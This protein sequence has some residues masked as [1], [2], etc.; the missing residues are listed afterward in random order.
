[1]MLRSPWHFP[2]GKTLPLALSFLG[3]TFVAQL[4][5]ATWGLFHS[6]NTSQDGPTIRL[7]QSP[8]ADSASPSPNLL[9]Q[10]RLDSLTIRPPWQELLE[11]SRT[12]A[13]NR[14]PDAAFKALNEAEALLPQ[15]PG[16]LAEMAVQYEKMGNSAQAIKLWEMVFRFGPSAGVYFSAADAKLSILKEH[17]PA[18][19]LA[20]GTAPGQSTPTQANSVL[21]KPG[22]LKFGKFASK[23]TPG[24]TPTHRSFSLSVPVQRLDNTPLDTA[25]VF[26]QVQFYDQI[27]GSALERTNGSVSG[28][29]ASSNVNWAS[30]KSQTLLV[31]Y[32]QGPK[33]SPR[34]VRR[35][36]GYVASVYY[37]EK[38]LDTRADPPRLGQQY[39]PPRMISKDATQ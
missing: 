6:P 26:I 10:P 23:D 2:S 4:I 14:Q 20:P 21:P 7:D 36:Y 37:K 39:P 28:K 19:A 22:L 8:A 5:L 24:N 35:Y 15:Q 13:A 27:N 16:A 34:E 31:T 30:Q 3:T 17:A 9:V 38:L 18:A 12:S 29:W 33:R 11:Q 32:S 1:M 25:D